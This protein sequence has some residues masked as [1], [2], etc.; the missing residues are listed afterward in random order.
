M[1]GFP[2]QVKIDTVS[3]G[4]VQFGGAVFVSPKNALKSIHGSGASNTGVNILN[5]NGP[6][7]T[8][9]VDTDVIDQPIVH[10]N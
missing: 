8:N 3:G 7:T 4:V 9:T 10:D 5:F 6:S 2:I 1:S